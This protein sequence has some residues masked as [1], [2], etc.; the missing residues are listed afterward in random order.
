MHSRILACTISE[1]SA[2]LS[3]LRHA[4]A[5]FQKCACACWGGAAV[6]GTGTSSR[7]A[8]RCGGMRSSA[9]VCCPTSML[10]SISLAASTGAMLPSHLPTSAGEFLSGGQ[11]CTAL[12][13]IT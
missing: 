12:S 6:A 8:A 4:I 1:A 7:A 9:P 2:C 11:T 3:I 10:S 5:T 13:M